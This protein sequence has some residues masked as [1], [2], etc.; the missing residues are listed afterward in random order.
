[1]L[2]M[3]L[4]GDDSDILLSC[5][6]VGRLKHHR[7]ASTA[8]TTPTVEE[9]DEEEEEDKGGDT[10]RRSSTL[11]PPSRVPPPNYEPDTDSVTSSQTARVPDAGDVSA[12]YSEGIRSECDCT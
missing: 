8:S 12:A 6:T 4:N 10:E 7:L 9:E 2:E 11:P 3:K 1:M 5:N